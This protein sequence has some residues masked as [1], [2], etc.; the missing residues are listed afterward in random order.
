ML[1]STGD[2]RTIMLSEVD[3]A[4]AMAVAAK[5]LPANIRA[6]VVEGRVSRQFLPG[7]AFWAAYVTQA[8]VLGED[9]CTR[10][11]YAVHMSDAG[12]PGAPPFEIKLLIGPVER[13]ELQAI[14]FPANNANDA[15][16][17]TT[18]G[19]VS[20]SGSEDDRRRI[21][22]YRQLV[23]AMRLAKTAKPLPFHTL[24]SPADDAACRDVRR[25]LANLPLGELYSIH[26][27]SLKSESEGTGRVRI[28]RMKQIQSS[29][30]YDI[31]LS[32]GIS[33]KDGK[34]WRVRWRET[35]RPLAEIRL[36]RAMVIYH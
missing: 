35:G 30:P 19:F 28:V 3:G 5:V 24:C 33:G 23:A 15:S 7:H 21:N 2:T 31:E 18:K 13:R 6:T 34:S 22:A 36:E 25:S 20:V 11:Q 17:A 8:R 29:D 10:T 4:E 32:F 27:M 1:L 12:A 9:L 26:V 14:V 16:C